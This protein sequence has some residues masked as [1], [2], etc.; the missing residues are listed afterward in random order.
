V[1]CILHGRRR[2][3]RRGLKKPRFHIK[4]ERI[5]HYLF[6]VK[7]PRKKRAAVVGITLDLTSLEYD[8]IDITEILS[9]IGDYSPPIVEEVS[10]TIETKERTDDEILNAISYCS[11]CPMCCR[12]IFSAGRMWRGKRLCENCHAISQKDIAPELTAYIKDIYSKGCTFCDNK[13]GRFH[14]DH[15]NM[16]TK[17]SSVGE[18][19]DRGDPA[20]DIIAEVAKCQLLCI[21][22]HSLV[23]RF[24]SKRGFLIKK[25]QLNKKMLAGEDVTE[26]KKKLYDEYEDVMRVMYPLIREKCLRTLGVAGER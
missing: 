3:R 7:M 4:S 21:N 17:I 15:I 24:E 12:G 16:F 18:M 1:A 2:L 19:M 25:R 23:T 20:E 26:M 8:D 6:L 5:F 14:L 11:V 22:C 9:K 13:C 10:P